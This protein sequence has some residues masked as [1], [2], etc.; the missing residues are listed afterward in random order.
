MGLAAPVCL[1]FRGSRGT[2][3]SRAAVD[4]RVRGVWASVINSLWTIRVDEKSVKCSNESPAGVVRG[5]WLVRD[6]QHT[7]APCREEAPDFH[8]WS[9]P[10]DIPSST[11]APRFSWTTRGWRSRCSRTEPRAEASGDTCRGIKGY[12]L[13][14]DTP[15]PPLV[16]NRCPGQEESGCAA[17]WRSG[18][19][20]CAV[21]AGAVAYGEVADKWWIS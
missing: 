4:V 11:A 13:P 14:R 12:V 8:T 17:P 2:R 18:V 3:E 20:R 16:R 5:H 6:G 1:Y 10:F 15:K 7:S 9:P 21:A 19:R